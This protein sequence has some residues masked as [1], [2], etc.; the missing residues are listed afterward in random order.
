MTKT[1]A[2]AIQAKIE[3]MLKSNK[4]HYK[5]EKVRTDRLSFINLTISIKVDKE[6]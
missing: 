5:L 4:I 2:E 6:E 1:E 3:C